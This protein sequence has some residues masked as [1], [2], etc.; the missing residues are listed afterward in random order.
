T[1]ATIGTLSLIGAGAIIALIKMMLRNRTPRPPRL[2]RI[3][4]F[5]RA[6]GL[7]Y[8]KTRQCFSAG[9]SRARGNARPSSAATVPRDDASALVHFSFAIRAVS[10]PVKSTFVRCAIASGLVTAEDIEAA[11]EKLRADSDVIGAEPRANDRRLADVLVAA[12]RLNA[13]Q[14][15][16]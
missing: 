4:N 10:Q 13:Y 16:Y 6:A 7:R 5:R 9:R 2:P 12:G 1:G 14:A 3:Q 15:N 11:E 8:N